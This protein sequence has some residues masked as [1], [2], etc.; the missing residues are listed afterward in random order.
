MRVRKKFKT[1]SK[2]F[3]LRV[4][5]K[6]KNLTHINA[7]PGVDAHHE[8]VFPSMLLLHA[9]PLA[10]HGATVSEYFDGVTSGPGVWKMRHYLEVYEQH[11]RRFSGTPVAMAEIGV[12]SGGSL[13]MWRWLFGE[14]A[15]LYGIDVS[16]KTRAYELNKN[17]GRPQKMFIGDKTHP[18]FWAE[19]KRSVPD[20]LDVIVDDGGH[21]PWQ[22]IAGFKLAWPLIRPGGVMIIEDVNQG[23][24]T[25]YITGKF[26]H[27]RTGIMSFRPAKK[28]DKL[29]ESESL[30]KLAHSPVQRE[31]AHVSFYPQMIVVEKMARPRSEIVAEK[32]GSEWQPPEF[33]AEAKAS[34]AAMQ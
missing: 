21:A 33:W 20:G 27:A 32:H 29:Q 19:L 15:K 31:L 6:Q 7:Q 28:F 18:Q 26:L 24:F 2:L 10:A 17:Y 8:R 23:N 1:Q 34:A 12:Y 30:I 14:A 16:A 25:Q 4:D 3:R 9:L 11:L 5:F 22:Q 13:K